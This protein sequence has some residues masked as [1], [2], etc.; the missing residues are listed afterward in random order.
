M[1][2]NR[3][4]E[5]EKVAFLELAH[6]MARSNNDFSQAQQSI[7]GQYC[8]EMQ[9]E[10]INY[11]EKD[12]NLS[13]ILKKIDNKSSQKIVLLEIMALVY[14]NQKIDK[15]EQE[16]LDAMITEFNLTSSLVIVYG[17]WAKAILAISIQGAALIEL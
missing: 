4:N 2:L 12:Y 3:L 17:E 16:V 14:S 10:D 5:D 13:E 9:I 7:I 11:D 6:H 1:F 15:E 8:L